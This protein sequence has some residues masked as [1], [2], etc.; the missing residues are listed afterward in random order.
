VGGHVAYPKLALG[1][2]Y[3]QAMQRLVLTPLGM[4]STTFDFARALRGNHAGAYSIDLDGKPVPAV[5]ALNY[6]AIPIRPAGGAWSSVRDLLKYVQME[7]AQ[8]VLPGG[9][10]YIAAEPLLARRAPQV[11]VSNDVTYGMGL[12]VDTTYGVPVVHHGGDLIGFHSDM[13]WLPEH[14]IGAVILTNSDGGHLIADA[15]GRKLLELVFNG[16]PE[17]DADIA[18]GSKTFFDNRAAE[19]KL[20]AVPADPTAA[21][22]LAARYKNAALGELAVKRR[23]AAV[24]FDLGEWQSEVG[25]RKNA[26]GT[27]SF[28]LTEASLHGLDFVL[29]TGEP[30]TLTVRDGQHV[31][32]FTAE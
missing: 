14:A 8:G 6:A 2:A 4:T 26:D 3:D 28:V 32:T 10:R 19:R 12:M 17:A 24:I 13:L 21:G 5:M 18:A 1:A 16:K 7:L 29:G 15:L 11:A 25:T 30:R 22:Q 20:L 31:Y 27:Q 23:G 9:K